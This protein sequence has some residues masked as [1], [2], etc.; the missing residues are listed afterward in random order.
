MSAAD[1]CPMF[2]QGGAGD[3]REARDHYRP[4]DEARRCLAIIYISVL[5]CIPIFMKMGV[6][7]EKDIKM[8]KKTDIMTKLHMWE[9]MGMMLSFEI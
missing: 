8:D 5:I 6:G 1:N 4:H 2:R 3:C 9:M 7:M